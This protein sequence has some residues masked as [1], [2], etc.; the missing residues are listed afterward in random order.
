MSEDPTMS[1]R[2]EYNGFVICAAPHNLAASGR[3]TVNITIERHRGDRV[4]DK[5]FSA[6]DAF[7]TRNEAV[8]HCFQFGKR[9]IDGEEPGL[10]VET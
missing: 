6:A 1:D 3:W 8:H 5:H 4:L 10:T 2:L 9:I 7:D